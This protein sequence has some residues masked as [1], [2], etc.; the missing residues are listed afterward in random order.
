MDTKWRYLVGPKLQLQIN[1]SSMLLK[2]MSLLENI[3]K[4]TPTCQQQE[5]Y[6]FAL[7]EGI[8]QSL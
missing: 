4:R 8:R 5:M 3:K 1:M 2:C 7:S 6:T